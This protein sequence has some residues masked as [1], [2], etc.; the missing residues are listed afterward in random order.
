MRG[1]LAYGRPSTKGT[2]GEWLTDDEG[3]VDGG[4]KIDGGAGGGSFRNKK[5]TQEVL[6]GLLPSVGLGLR[7]KPKHWRSSGGVGGV[8]HFW[9]LS[10]A[11]LRTPPL[12]L[13]EYS[14]KNLISAFE[15]AE[16]SAWIYLP[17][18]FLR[19]FGGVEFWRSTP[20]KMKF[21]YSVSQP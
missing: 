6:T 16:Y 13:T 5:P 7:V 17:P 1:M 18:Y 15:K 4:E 3:R 8:V 21:H 12:N 14:V 20:S 11:L 19:H 2:V 10:T 9:P